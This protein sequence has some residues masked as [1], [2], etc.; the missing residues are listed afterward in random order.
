MFRKVVWAALRIYERLH[1]DLVLARQ[2][3]GTPVAR[4]N[5]DAGYSKQRSGWSYLDTP[6]ELGRY[7]LIASYAH[8]LHERPTILEIGCGHGSLLELLVR[9]GF[10]RYL[11]I[12][13]SSEAIK[14]AKSLGIEKASFEVADFETWHRPER[15]D[16]IVFNESL[17]Y[18]KQPTETLL[19]YADSLCENGALI[20]SMHRSG[21]HGIIWN[22][23]FDHFEVAWS[24][25]IENQARQAWDVRVL[26]RKREP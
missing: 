22:K 17:Y 7:A 23:L 11:G 25:M 24:T 13:H 2:G 26:M 10:R 9:F 6:T 19:R 20:V 16:I 3:Y 8:N 21:N 1:Y 18:A 15:F 14:R 12:D 4:E 5:W